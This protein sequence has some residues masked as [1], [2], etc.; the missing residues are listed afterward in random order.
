[1]TSEQDIAGRIAETLKDR[2]THEAMPAVALKA[3]A[4]VIPAEGQG[5]KRDRALSALSG[6]SHREL[7]DIACR[8]GAHFADFELEE[9]GLAIL[10]QGEPAIT[11]IT[12]RDVARCFG[13]DLSGEL[14]VVDLVRKHFPIESPLDNIFGGSS[15]A[16]DIAQHM[17]RNPGD[18]SVE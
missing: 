11:E 12:R 1:M 4:L 8:L 14:N 6:K 5:S 17:I 2:C 16:R 15:L 18:W 13:D 3:A 9:A 10:E 7:G